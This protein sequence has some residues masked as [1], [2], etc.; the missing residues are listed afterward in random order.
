VVSLPA[1]ASPVPVTPAAAA[2][3]A[4]ST[5]PLTPPPRTI[6]EETHA[7]PESVPAAAPAPPPMPP[8]PLLPVVAR[9]G[10][11]ESSGDV[12]MLPADT[13]GDGAMRAVVTAINAANTAAAEA[14]RTLN[15]SLLRAAYEGAALDEM[16][17]GV[18]ALSAAGRRREH[19]LREIE[20]LAIR[21]EG[22]DRAEVRTRERWRT[23]TV[24]TRDG[25]LL[26]TLD[27]WYEQIYRLV[28]R[29]G[30]WLVAANE[31][32]AESAA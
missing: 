20:L 2:G 18:G 8:A 24:A 21:L 22:D 7:A 25:R 31:V 10:A 9:L 3:A 12:A 13:F 5:E 4:R 32:V 11:G 23:E 19:T 16:S 28:R 27:R 1:P 29:E 6:E 30:G 14:E 26:S 15:P 17:S